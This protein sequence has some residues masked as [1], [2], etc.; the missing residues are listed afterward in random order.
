MRKNLIVGGGCRE[1]ALVWKLPHQLDTGP[2]FV[3]PDTSCDRS[4]WRGAFWHGN[5][6]HP[7]SAQAGATAVSARADT[8]DWST[9]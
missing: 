3:A 8:R 2:A 6:G 1:R 5:T 7:A 4:H 9:P